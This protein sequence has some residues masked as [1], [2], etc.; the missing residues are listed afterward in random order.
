MGTI[1]EENYEEMDEE[2]QEERKLIGNLLIKNYERDLNDM[3]SEQLN[4]S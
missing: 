4:Q 1:I 2:D 3:G